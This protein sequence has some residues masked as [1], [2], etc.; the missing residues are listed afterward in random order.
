MVR[1]LVLEEREFDSEKVIDHTYIDEG[2]FTWSM[3]QGFRFWME[4]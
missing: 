1:N 4:V 2:D 3:I